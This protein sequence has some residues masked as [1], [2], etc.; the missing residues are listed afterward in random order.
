MSSEL[1]DLTADENLL[2]DYKECCK[3]KVVVKKGTPRAPSLP[4]KSSNP[5]GTATAL[6]AGD[7][8]SSCGGE[9]EEPLL[10]PK[11]KKGTNKVLAAANTSTTREKTRLNRK[12][13]TASDRRH[14]AAPS[15]SLKRLLT[16]KEEQSKVLVKKSELHSH[17]L[18]FVPVTLACH[19]SL[20]NVQ[21]Q[22]STVM[23]YRRH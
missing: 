19:L 11:S 20:E 7:A 21:P 6:H 14:P 22:L 9:A 2:E 10:A 8:A 4:L 17:A 1:I 23:T 16:R 5:D 13:L 12:R 15:S 18:F 3:G